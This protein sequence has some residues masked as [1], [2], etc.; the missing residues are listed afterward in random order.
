MRLLG[1]PMVKL[2]DTRDLKSLG[3]S[4][5]GSTPVPGTSYWY[6][7]AQESPSN[8]HSARLC[9]FFVSYA[10]YSLDELL[11]N[12]IQPGFPL[13]G[14]PSVS[15]NCVRLLILVWIQTKRSE[16]LAS[17]LMQRLAA[18]S[19]RKTSLSLSYRSSPSR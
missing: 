1:G 14:T 3:A 9:G 18:G 7:A 6:K 16:P 4:C 2:V 10:V 5:T 15:V 11:S 13:A 8:P 12:Y 19:T 17:A